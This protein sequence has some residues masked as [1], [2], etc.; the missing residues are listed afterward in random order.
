MLNKHRPSRVNLSVNLKT[1]QGNKTIKLPHKI[2]VIGDFSA[3]MQNM[4]LMK[5][6][7]HR[8][9]AT[10]LDEIMLLLNPTVDISLKPRLRAEGDKLHVKLSFKTLHDF[11]PDSLVKRLPELSNLLA[12]RHL[13]KELRSHLT[14]SHDFKVKMQ[15]L[16]MEDRI[17]SS[18]QEG[19]L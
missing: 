14:E 16:L 7:R 13:L 15:S 8:I 10:S 6:Q 2:L 11:H 17:T 19:S 12:M 18:L 1:E 4:P 3:G 9:T 5:K